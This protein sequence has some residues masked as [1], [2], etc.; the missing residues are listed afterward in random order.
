MNSKNIEILLK[1]FGVP[2]P[3]IVKIKCYDISGNVIEVKYNHEISNAS[4]GSQQAYLSIASPLKFHATK[5]IYSFFVSAF[6]SSFLIPFHD[7]KIS[8]STNIHKV[9]FIMKSSPS[10]PVTNGIANF[11]GQIWV[12]KFN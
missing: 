6:E 7:I 2:H 11:N 1:P 12:R 8:S 5:S 4:D 3:T 10:T 9:E